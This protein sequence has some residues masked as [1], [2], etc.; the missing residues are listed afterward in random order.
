MILTCLSSMIFWFHGACVL[1]K[2]KGTYHTLKVTSKL[3]EG[4]QHPLEWGFGSVQWNC[5]LE[6]GEERD[7]VSVKED[8]QIHLKTMLRGS[9]KIRIQFNLAFS[10]I[11]GFKNYLTTVY[12]FLV[13]YGNS[14]NISCLIFQNR[15]NIIHP[16]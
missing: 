1:C 3:S 16:V 10:V 11:N 15:D 5:G 13:N 4:F 6:T 8:S 2:G 14:L 9:E 7:S 12:R